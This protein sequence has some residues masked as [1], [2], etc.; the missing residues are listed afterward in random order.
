M[1]KIVFGCFLFFL[2]AQ[3]NLLLSADWILKGMIEAPVDWDKVPEF[4][5]F[6]EGKEYTT[7][8]EGFISFPVEEK[9]FKK[10]SILICK[11]FI[12]TFQDVNN[13][14]HFS[15]NPGKS[16]KYITFKKSLFDEG[17][18]IRKD[19]TL[20]KKQFVVP[21]NCL[22][23]I[24]NPKYVDKVEEWKMNLAKNFVKLPKIVLKKDLDQKK[25]SREAAK[26]L[27]YTLGDKVFHETVK[28]A[29]QKPKPNVTVALA[30]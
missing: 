27:L 2:L 12:P 4:R 21:K 22:I 14:E 10:Y 23:M 1:K 24:I 15:I 20:N 9:D 3:S 6:F 26:S 28:V 19:K 17:E 7:D 8:S 30:Q 13:I 18:W 16:Y 25:V 11:Q 5:V 29:K